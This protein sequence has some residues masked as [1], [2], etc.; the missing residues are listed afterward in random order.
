ME[1]VYGLC[2]LFGI[3]ASW[4]IL[5]M[6]LV[7]AANFISRYFTAEAIFDEEPLP[8]VI[9]FGPLLLIWCLY[10]VWLLIKCCLA[11]LYRNIGRTVVV[12]YA[13]KYETSYRDGYS[14]CTKKASTKAMSNFFKSYLEKEDSK[15]YLSNEADKNAL[16]NF[17]R[18]DGWR[19]V[20]DGVWTKIVKVKDLNI[21]EG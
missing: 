20:G 18:I 6:L 11:Y 1:V 4:F 10:P 5:G 3:I 17:L 7:Y 13:Y 2:I 14:C 15:F 9:V 16:E 12:E 8:M 21:G 19:N